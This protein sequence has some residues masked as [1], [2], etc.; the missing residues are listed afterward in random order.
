M[1]Y[2]RGREDEMA[3][4]ENN[5]VQK[6]MQQ[7]ELLYDLADLFKVLGDSTR[8]RILCVLYNGEMC[9]NDIAEVL[10]MTTS[11]ISHQLRTLKQSRLVKFRREGKTIFYDLDDDHVFS[12]LRQGMEHIQ[13]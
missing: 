5:A 8:I 3:E 10:G 12:I 11:A 4:K 6:A 9:V 2:R 7:E 13:E 1:T